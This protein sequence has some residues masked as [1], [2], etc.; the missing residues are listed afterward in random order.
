[1]NKNDEIKTINSFGDEWEKFDQN[2]LDQKYLEYDFK[3]YFKVFPFDLIDKSSEGFDMGCGTGRWSKFIAP[4]VKRL[5]CIEPSDAIKVAKSKLNEFTNITFYKEKILDCSLK[6]NS[7][8]FGYVL[9]VLHHLP[10]P[11]IGLKRCVDLL[12]PGA[13]LLIYFYYSFENRPFWFRYFWLLS[14]LIRKLVSKMP[15]FVKNLLCEIIAFLVYLPFSRLA[16]LSE[17]LNL[18]FQNLPLYEYKDKPIYTLRTDARDRFGTVI[19]HRMS[20]IEILSMMKKS[21]LTNIV[22]SEETPYWCASAIKKKSI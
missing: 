19:E 1:M 2:S 12:K 9:G 18:N 15:H 20:K 5:N 10:D 11:L 13:P 3:K 7:Q 14:N 17:I 8:D 6:D 21:N 22:F 4:R 16:K